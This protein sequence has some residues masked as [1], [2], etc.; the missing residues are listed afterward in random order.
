MLSMQEVAATLGV[1]KRTVRRYFECGL[2]PRP[3]R[4]GPKL[5]RFFKSDVDAFV[6]RLREQ[7]AV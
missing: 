6:H 1:C 7:K 2:L 3:K 5:L 4:M